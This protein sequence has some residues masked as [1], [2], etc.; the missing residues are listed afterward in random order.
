MKRKDAAIV[1][2]SKGSLSC[3]ATHFI[4]D[5]E[6]ELFEDGAKVF[7][8]TWHERIKRDMV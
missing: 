3:D 6:L 7:S 4:I 8:R 2:H 5:M 1:H